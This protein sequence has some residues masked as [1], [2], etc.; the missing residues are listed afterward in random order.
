MSLNDFILSLEEEY[1]EISIGL[2]NLL[3]DKEKEVEI[4]HSLWSS[5]SWHD[6]Y[7]YYWKVIGEIDLSNVPDEKMYLT[8]DLVFKKQDDIPY[9]REVKKYFEEMKKRLQSG[10]CPFGNPCYGLPYFQKTTNGFEV[11]Y[12]TP[13]AL[14]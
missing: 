6:E 14:L 13:L 9:M 1:R 2:K 8:L 5:E 10:Y 11:G 12:S 4:Y 7:T 3:N